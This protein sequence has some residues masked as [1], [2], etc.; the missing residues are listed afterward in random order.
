MM[1]ELN[2]KVDN[3]SDKQLYEDYLIER[4]KALY[5]NVELKEEENNLNYFLIQ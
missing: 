3:S 5:S 2:I 1:E 4:N